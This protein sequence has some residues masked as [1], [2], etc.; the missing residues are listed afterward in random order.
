MDRRTGAGISLARRLAE[1]GSPPSSLQGRRRNPDSWL[2]AGA[3]TT[4][5]AD[6]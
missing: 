6:G 2:V 4:T 5:P 3:F 1:R